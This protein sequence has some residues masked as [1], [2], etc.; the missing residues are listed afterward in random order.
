[1]S[2]FDKRKAEEEQ[3]P[4]PVDVAARVAVPSS[5]ATS[6]TLPPERQGPQP[7]SGGTN[8]GRGV[9]IKGEIHSQEDLLIDG[10]LEGTLNLGGHRLV[11]GP[12]GRVRA[13]I[14]AREVEVH[15]TVD[16]NVEAAERIILRKNSKMVGDL[17]MIS[18]VI[19]DGAYF[20]GSIDIQKPQGSG[21]TAQPAGTSVSKA[22]ST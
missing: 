6:A 11:I 17:K 16:G 3:I 19:E 15:G 12:N 4:R 1:M 14:G 21:L 7:G 8:I 2:I 13:S 5:Q 18:V 10:H 20:K 22:S 9:T